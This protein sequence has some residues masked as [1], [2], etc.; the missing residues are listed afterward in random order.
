MP[1]SRCD[2]TELLVDQCAHCRPAPPA[3]PDERSSSP[4]DYGQAFTARYPGVCSEGGD[5]IHEGD[6]IRYCGYEGTYAHDEC[7]D[8]TR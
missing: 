4:G 8:S 7:L 3:D 1:E 5:R 6:L 2:I